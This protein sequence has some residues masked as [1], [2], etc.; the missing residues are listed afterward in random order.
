MAHKLITPALGLSE[1]KVV[2]MVAAKSALI[3]AGGVL[4]RRS[5]R[6]VDPGKLM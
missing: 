3:E 6:L 5:Y 4:V 1:R 2:N